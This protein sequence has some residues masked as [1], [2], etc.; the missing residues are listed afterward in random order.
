M[1]STLPA[2]S[3]IGP[4]GVVQSQT[5]T[6]A[7]NAVSGA[8]TYQLTIVDQATGQNVTNPIV[9]TGT[10][11]TAPSGLLTAGH[12]YSWNVTA[13]NSGGTSAVS[14]NLVFSTPA[15]Q[16]PVI[17]TLAATA[18][19]SSQVNL[20]WSASGAVSYNLYEFEHGGAVLIGSYPA[21]TTSATIN[22]LTGGTS[23]AFD[24]VAFTNSGPMATAWVGATTF[25]AP[26][27]TVPTLLATAASSSQVN[28]NWSASGAVEL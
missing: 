4:S 23:Y 10:S 25:V 20:N 6:F 2:P 18:A 27:P 15:P 19:S 13:I 7:W 21:G 22:G 17:P 1:I 28:L 12:A 3:Q 14:S 9:L 16:A 11:Y 26:A 5:P 24:M 8:S